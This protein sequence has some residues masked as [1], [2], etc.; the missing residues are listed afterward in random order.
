[1]LVISKPYNFRAGGDAEALVAGS[2]RTSLG[3]GLGCDKERAGWGGR[4]MS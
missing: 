3:V 4:A 1:M 2:S